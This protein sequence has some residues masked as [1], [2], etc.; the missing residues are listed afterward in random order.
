MAK[1]YATRQKQTDRPRLWIMS[2]TENKER[3]KTRLN[4]AEVAQVGNGLSEVT[5]NQHL[6]K[7]MKMSAR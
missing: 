6:G 3:S 7:S 1:K 5:R 4:G 2:T